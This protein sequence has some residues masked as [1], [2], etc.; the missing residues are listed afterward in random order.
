VQDIAVPESTQFSLPHKLLQAL[1]EIF[2][3]TTFDLLLAYPAGAGHC[4]A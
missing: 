3:L 2:C 1:Q 4:S